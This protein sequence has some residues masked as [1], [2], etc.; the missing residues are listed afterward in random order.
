MSFVFTLITKEIESGLKMTVRNCGGEE[1][2]SMDGAKLRYAAL[3][4]TEGRI[5]LSLSFP[6]PVDSR[7][8]V[9]QPVAQ[10]TGRC[11][12]SVA[13]GDAVIPLVAK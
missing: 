1:S 7:Q 4:T 2:A 11:A 8:S 5:F 9:S 10:W 13:L 12:E 6:H 3:K